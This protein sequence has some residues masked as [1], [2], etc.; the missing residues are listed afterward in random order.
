MNRKILLFFVFVT[1]V[2]SLC[3]KNDIDDRYCME[4]NSALLSK[5]LIDK[6]GKDKIVELLDNDIYILFYFEIDKNG[7]IKPLRTLISEEKPEIIV[8]LRPIPNKIDTY[9]KI[10]TDLIKDLKI[11]KDYFSICIQESTG[12]TKSYKI[13]SKDIFGDCEN[14]AINISFPGSLIKYYNIE[15]DKAN[16][17]RMVLTKYDYFLR[18]VKKYASKIME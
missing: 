2:G 14:I 17:N 10:F 7:N 1:I 16:D 8:P 18:Q 3:A 6:L 12:Y 13:N 15:R 5:I 9:D 4:K 11:K